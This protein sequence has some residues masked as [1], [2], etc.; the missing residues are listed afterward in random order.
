MNLKKEED[1]RLFCSH[2]SQTIKDKSC[3]FFLFNGGIQCQI[4]KGSAAVC[5]PATKKREIKKVSVNTFER[6]WE[7]H[8]PK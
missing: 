4:D 3:F 1:T 7:Q 6:V 8:Q 2:S 5:G